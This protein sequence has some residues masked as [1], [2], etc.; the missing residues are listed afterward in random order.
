MNTAVLYAKTFGKYKREKC[1]DKTDKTCIYNIFDGQDYF[2]N[3]ILNT[4]GKKGAKILK[5]N[6]ICFRLEITLWKKQNWS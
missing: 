3:Y 6:A 5:S 1:P 2:D 4:K